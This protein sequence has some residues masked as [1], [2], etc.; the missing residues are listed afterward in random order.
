MTRHTSA[1][2]NPVASDLAKTKYGN[3]NG[4]IFVSLLPFLEQDVLFNNG[5]MVLPSGRVETG[6]ACGSTRFVPT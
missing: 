2:R 4:G 1:P 5:A 6:G 3:Y